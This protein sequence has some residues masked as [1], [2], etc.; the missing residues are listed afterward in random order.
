MPGA[1]HSYFAVPVGAP[2]VLVAPPGAARV[3]RTGTSPLASTPDLER[4]E[5]RDGGGD[6]AGRGTCGPLELGNFIVQPGSGG[7]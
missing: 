3:S 1:G 6:D 7:S 2:L 5:H 4:D